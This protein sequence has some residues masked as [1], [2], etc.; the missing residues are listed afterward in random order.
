MALSKVNIAEAATRLGQPFAPVNL[1]TVNDMA[2]NLIRCEGKFQWHMHD[3]MDEIFY[4][5]SGSMLLETELGNVVLH[6]GELVF[7][8]ANVAHCPSAVRPALVLFCIKYMAFPRNGDRRTLPRHDKLESKVNLAQRARLLKP[9]A[10]EDVATF[11]DFVLRALVCDG[12]EAMH[13]HA[14]DDELALVVEGAVE[15]EL[16]EQAVELQAGELIVVPK[17]TPHRLRADARATVLLL[18]RIKV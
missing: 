3:Q 6:A 13:A 2:V 16:A 5:H 14:H 15:L 11:D 7:A 18:S 8:P 10:A 12:A 1:A 4:V 17:N 9:F